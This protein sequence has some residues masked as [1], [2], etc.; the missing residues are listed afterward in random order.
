MGAA[1]SKISQRKFLTFQ[2][3]SPIIV[4]I[5]KET[6][7][8]KKRVSKKAL[9]KEIAQITGRPLYEFDSLSR[10]NIQTIQW[11]KSLIS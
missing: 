4:Y 1:C 6:K 10:A 8:T 5:M 7:E 3:S 2:E 11:V 9:I